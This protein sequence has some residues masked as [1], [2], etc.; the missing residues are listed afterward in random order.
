M[1]DAC[2]LENG[3]SRDSSAMAITIIHDLGVPYG[4]S[5]HHISRTF[6]FDFEPEEDARGGRG[7]HWNKLQWAA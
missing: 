6:R 3:L 7:Q 1:A 5:D 4:A 2:H